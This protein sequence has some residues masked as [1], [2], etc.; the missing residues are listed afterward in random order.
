MNRNAKKP[1]I[2]ALVVAAGRGRRA[3]GDI[4]KQ[5]ARIGGQPVLRHT[6]RALSR[7][8]GIDAI[9]TV[10]HPDDGSLYAACARN[11]GKL[12]AP[13]TGGASRQESVRLGLESLA[14]LAPEKVLI[15]DGARPFIDAALISRVIAALD[16]HDGALAALPVTDTLKEVSGGI[17]TGT[18]DRANLWRAQTP[19]G[20]AFA[21]IL[22]AHQQAAL[23]DRTDFTD[24]AAVAEWAGIRTTVIKGSAGNE[25]IT[26]AEDLVMADDKLT[27]T[28]EYRTGTG[29]DVHRFCQGSQITLCGI[30]ISH[31][32][33]LQGHSDADVALHAL[34]DALLGTIA[35]GDIG[36]HFPPSD[37][38]WAGVSSDRFAAHAAALVR[39]RGG[40]I[41]NVDVTIICEAP[42]IGPHRPAMQAE[43]ARILEV[44]PDRVSIKAT[45][46]E[47]LGFT[48]R[49]EG[50]AAQASVSVAL[51]R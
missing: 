5:Y 43:I 7:T 12:L 39:E 6:L 49:R 47:G 38:Q 16:H 25:K 17:V 29:F 48:G 31:D 45:T 21:P 37:P 28:D 2:A 13:V 46:T 11:I 40:R 20:F 33:S 51:S 26:L 10:I 41:I 14:R 36:T 3:G 19:Q 24:D 34:T 32:M 4:A 1:A 42:G 18:R 8:P 44:T 9:L 15:H 30:N 50:I 23:D 35:A 22:A 27:R